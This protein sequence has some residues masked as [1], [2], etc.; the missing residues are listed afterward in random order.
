MTRFWAEID[1]H[2]TVLLLFL[3][4]SLPYFGWWWLVAVVL[5]PQGRIGVR[6]LI[7]YPA[8]KRPKTGYILVNQLQVLVAA[9]IAIGLRAATDGIRS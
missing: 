7:D 1:L 5:I 9:V 8:M 2:V 4:P 3:T 6:A